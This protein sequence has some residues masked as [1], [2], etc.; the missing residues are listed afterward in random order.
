[1]RNRLGLARLADCLDYPQTT[2]AKPQHLVVVREQRWAVSG[3][4]DG[5]AEVGEHA[6][7]PGLRG[8]GQRAGALV[9]D[10]EPAARE[11]EAG[12]LQELLLADTQDVGPV[13][14]GV[15]P[16]HADRDVGEVHTTQHVQ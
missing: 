8:H 4:D 5:R 13:G 12:E 15:Q 3:T 1:M 6:V 14:D 16:A 11:Q 7:K 2:A 9:N 10:D